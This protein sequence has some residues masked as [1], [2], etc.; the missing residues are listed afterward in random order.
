M[1]NSVILSLGSGYKV[2]NNSGEDLG[3]VEEL[4]VDRESS[5]VMYA[6][7]A[8][9]GFLQGGSRLTAV[10]WGRLQMEVD[11]KRFLLNIDKETLDNAPH[12]D[13]SAW[14]DM[15]LPEWRESTE[16]YFAYNPADESEA[17]E[18]GEFIETGTAS[19]SVQELSRDERLAR[20]VEF[21]L[22][23]TRAFDMD[24]IQ[25]TS[26]DRKVTIRG[27]VNS[28]AEAILAENTALSVEGVMGVVNSL[29]ID[30]AA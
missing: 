16:T 29:T 24:A 20:N 8:Q 2:Q 27:R 22:F 1:F 23:A 26:R 14:P 12:F 5:R 6:V 9:G 15:T 21:E 18:G 30:K 28:R 4:V 19:S 11:Q 7:L 13:R 3:K 17:V 25:A 10:P